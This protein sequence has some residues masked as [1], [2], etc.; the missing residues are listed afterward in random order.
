M[1]KETPQRAEILRIFGEIEEERRLVKVMSM[2]RTGDQIAVVP[3]NGCPDDKKGNYFCG[4][5][6]W[7]EFS[8]S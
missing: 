6:R 2:R 1:S 8:G 4:W 3:L 5:L 7:G